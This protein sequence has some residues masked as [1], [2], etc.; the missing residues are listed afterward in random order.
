M[1]MWFSV[2]TAHNL[3]V[4]WTTLKQLPT[5]S[6]SKYCIRGGGYFHQYDQHTTA[7][8]DG[9]EEWTAISDAIMVMQDA[10]AMVPQLAMVT[11]SLDAYFLAG[12]RQ[13]HST[14]IESIQN[15]IIIDGLTDPK[16]KLTT[17]RAELVGATYETLQD[18][19]AL[20]KKSQ[21]AQIKLAN[22]GYKNSMVQQPLKTLTVDNC[23]TANK[24]NAEVATFN[25]K[26]ARARAKV[27]ANRSRFPSPSRSSRARKGRRARR[28]L[29]SPSR[30]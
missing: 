15:R 1:K 12:Q 29:T 7:C 4:D 10:A 9:E 6:A 21:A 17:K 24:A 27:N 13:G 3:R 23:K 28:R 30:P 25:N 5:E 20:A 14:V 2:N 8:P 26:R 11:R 16:I 18:A 19:I 22:T